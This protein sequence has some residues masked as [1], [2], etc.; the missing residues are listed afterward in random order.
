MIADGD[1]LV[2]RVAHDLELELLP[3]H[4]R[5]LHQDLAD[6]ARPEAAGRDDAQLLDVVDQTAARSSHRVR[7]PDHH[8][9]AKPGGYP[10]RVFHAV[11][12]LTLGH[13]DAEAVHGLL[14]GQTVLATLDGVRA[15]ADDLHAVAIQDPGAVELRA[16][17]QARLAAQVREQRVGTLLLD[18]LREGREVEG[19]DVGGV[20]HHGVGHDGRRIRVDQHDLVAEPAEGLACLGARVVELT[21]LADD[22]GAGTDDEHLR[23]VVASRHC[24][25][26][27]VPG[28]AGRLRTGLRI[29]AC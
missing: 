10:L 24:G 17:V 2:L 20:G 19:L 16:E 26:L 9:V 14:E 29:S 27:S 28:R 18:D 22:D 11:R 25:V 23:N 4:H 5:L 13:L 8:R 1:H 21:R 7:G 6:E 15:H 3:A 12:G